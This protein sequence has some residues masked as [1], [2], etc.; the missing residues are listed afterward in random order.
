MIPEHLIKEIVDLQKGGHSIDLI[1]SEGW[2]NAVFSS[3]PLPLGY[4]KTL[5]TLLLKLPVSYP[6]GRPDMFWT[7]KDLVLE[8]RRI[9]KGADVIEVALGQKWRRFSWH[10]QN[11]NPGTD[12]LATYIE[13]VNKGLAKARNLP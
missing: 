5:T 4:S 1:E 7:D 13:F 8:D 10:P 12:S 3:F 9:P 11:W 2:I 6:N